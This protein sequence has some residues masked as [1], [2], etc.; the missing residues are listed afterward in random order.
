MNKAGTV[1]N[2]LLGCQARRA[3]NVCNAVEAKSEGCA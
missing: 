2:A 3:D 1:H